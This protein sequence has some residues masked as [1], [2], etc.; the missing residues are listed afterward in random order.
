MNSNA[1]RLLSLL[2]CV[3]ILIVGCDSKGERCRKCGML[4]DQAPRWIAGLTNSTGA[5]ERFCCERC[6][7]AHL[8]SPE[9]AQARGAWVT[10]Y[11]TQQ[12]LPVGEVLFVMGSDITGPMGKALVPIAGRPAAEQFM[13]DHYGSRTLTADEITPDVLREVAGR[14]PGPPG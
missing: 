9:G 6:M 2:G 13:K 8:R 14:L 10:E 4:V 1:V 12:R 5:Q 3:A 7:F 11:Y